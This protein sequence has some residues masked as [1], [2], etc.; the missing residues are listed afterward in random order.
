MNWFLYLLDFSIF[1][2]STPEYSLDYILIK[3]QKSINDWDFLLSERLVAR[4]L[5]F[6]F[7]SKILKAP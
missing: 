6:C 3:E 7:K 4:V 1:M 2:D 5:D